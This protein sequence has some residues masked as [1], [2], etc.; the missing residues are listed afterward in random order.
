MA[1]LRGLT[2]S[3]IRSHTTAGGCDAGRD[4]AV[5]AEGG[6][7]PGGGQAGA[8][9]RHRLRCLLVR[10]AGR[11]E[12]L[13]ALWVERNG[14]LPPRTH[15]LGFLGDEVGVPPEVRGDVLLVNPVFDLVRYPDPTT[16]D[17]PVDTVDIEDA[18][19]HLAAAE[20]I[21]TWLRAQLSL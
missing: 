8:R 1:L 2:T 20:R 16:G 13:K 10:A 7:R 18:S 3:G 17:A 15:D 12:G 6:G 21:F 19:E 4:G 14:V 5:V 11:G 9:G